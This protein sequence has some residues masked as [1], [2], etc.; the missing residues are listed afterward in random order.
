[1]ANPEHIAKLKQGIKTWNRWRKKYP[2]IKPDLSK[3][4][5]WKMDLSKGNFQE[6]NFEE[7]DL[8]GSNIKEANFRK[9]NC[10]K[11]KFCKVKCGIT[12]KSIRI[13]LIGLVLLNSVLSFYISKD[14]LINN[15]IY[16]S[17]YSIINIIVFFITYVLSIWE[18]NIKSAFVGLFVATVGVFWVYF[19]ILCSGIWIAPAPIL[20]I[21]LLTAWLFKNDWNEK[22]FSE[23]L[24][25]EI[26]L[27]VK[28]MIGV[29]LPITLISIVFLGNFGIKEVSIP[30]NLLSFSVFQCVYVSRKIIRN[31]TNNAA[32]EF[33]AA[34][35]GTRFTDA[36]LTD[37]KFNQTD[38]AFANFLKST[39]VRSKWKSV[40]NVKY[41][42]FRKTIFD[43]SIVRNLVISK[44]IEKDR[45]YSNLNLQETNL[46][47][48][49]FSN[50]SLGNTDLTG[51]NLS[52][53][54]FFETNLMETKLDRANLSNANFTGAYI[55]TK[56]F[57]RNTIL[58]G[59]KAEYIYLKLPKEGDR[60]PN[61]MPPK[62]QGDFRENDFYIFIT[63]VLDTLDLYHRQDMNAGV[64]ITVLK[65]LAKDYLV[66][67]ELAGLDKR[68][69]NQYILKLKVFGQASHFQLKREYY[70]RYEQ[71]LLL[72]DPEKKLMPDT[73]AIVE[74]IKSMKRQP[75]TY[76]EKF[77]NERGIFIS[78]EEVS[79]TEGNNYVIQGDRNQA[80]Q[81]DNNQVTQEN[82]SQASD[83]EK[84]TQTQV[85]ELLAELE[86]KIQQSTLPEDVKDNNIKLLETSAVETQEEEP[87]K[88]WLAGNF[89][90]VTKNL[91][92]AREA[93]EEGKKLWNEVFPL[94]KT[95]GKWGGVAASFFSQ[96]L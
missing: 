88:Q 49:D 9:A 45:D 93:T 53:A 41:A 21:V 85:I 2:L 35:K 22:D 4:I 10:K 64:A 95:V 51:A 68:G 52:N 82:Y 55:D 65:G 25:K 1:M 54:K 96:F 32:T 56:S 43:D 75:N 36:N 23:I 63:S 77:Y 59:A 42:S 78:A 5:L 31:K 8:T 58:D 67:F 48:I 26:Y 47:N 94:L 69:N 39:I 84:L 24:M 38:I 33:L 92:Q 66:Q 14:Y 3:A 72:Y 19:G 70:D 12:Y 40:E 80:V 37:A 18:K 81:G 62:K 61:R 71:A 83:E 46:A 89:K 91:S 87:D 74:E 73:Q 30:S 50:T 17:I 57:T 76:I 7:T 29:S 20:L 28:I 34:L 6:V 60:D 90:R 13:I 15:N 11:A 86:E 27:I 16:N 79:M 44:E